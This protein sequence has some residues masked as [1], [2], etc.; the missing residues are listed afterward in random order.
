MLSRCNGNFAVD[1]TKEVIFLGAGYGEY[2]V[3][4]SEFI[5]GRLERSNHITSSDGGNNIGD[6][7]YITG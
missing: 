7:I 5:C 4:V 1:V 6:D 3:D 2:E